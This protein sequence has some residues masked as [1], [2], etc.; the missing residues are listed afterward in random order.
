MV[1][2]SPWKSVLLSEILTKPV[3]RIIYDL[4]TMEVYKRDAR[5]GYHPADLERVW[6]DGWIKTWK[7]SKS[8][9]DCIGSVAW[10]QNLPPPQNAEL[11]K[12]VLT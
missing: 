2:S 1:I 12:A 8:G 6:R 10:M 7:I 5:C 9:K 3:Q 4:D 11:D